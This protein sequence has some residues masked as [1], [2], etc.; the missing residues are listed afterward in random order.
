MLR[1]LQSDDP[2]NMYIVRLLDSFVHAGPNGNH[3][4]LVLELLGPNVDSANRMEPYDTANTPKLEE[5]LEPYTVVRISHQ[6]LQGLAFVH[7]AGYAQG[8]KTQT[9]ALIPSRFITNEKHVQ[10]PAHAILPLPVLVPKIAPKK[11]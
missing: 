1:A 11:S 2:A 3:L 7:K 8:G 4:C 6:L 5:N 9:R 10:M